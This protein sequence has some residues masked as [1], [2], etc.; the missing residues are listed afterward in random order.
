MS[1]GWDVWFG[2]PSQWIP[3]QD[4]DT[5]R[6]AMHIAVLGGNMHM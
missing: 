3:Y 4:I 2:I 6:E 1:A 5:D